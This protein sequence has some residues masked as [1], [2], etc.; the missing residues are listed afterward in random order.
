MMI[1]VSKVRAL[2]AGLV[3]GLVPMV[4]QAEPVN[5]TVRVEN[6]APTNS[7]SFA[8]LH[9]GFHNGSFDA[10][11]NGGVATAPIISIAEGGSGSA[12]FPAFAAADPGAVLGSVGA[13][14]LQPGISATA[15]FVV[16]PSMNSFFTFGS[17]VV[18]SN[19]L[20]IGNDSPTRYRLFDANGDLAINSITQRGRDIWNAGSEAAD[21]LNAAFVQ[22]GT[23]ALRTPENGVVE[24]SFAE[25]DVFQGLTT[26]GGYVFD[27]QFGGDTELYRIS[28]SVE[29]VAAQAVPAP[30]ALVLGMVGM[31]AVGCVRRLRARKLVVA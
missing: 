11:D 2:V 17:M 9:V 29:P 31:F 28:F 14:A 25:L 22:G 5:V 23:N 6:L 20:F 26:A 15:S 16:D 7:V 19:D 21:P 10:F 1:H 3:V 24:F 8:P 13:G 18:P 27:R 30:P 4:A 12:W